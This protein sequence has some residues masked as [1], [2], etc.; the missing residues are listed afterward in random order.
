MNAIKTTA[1][2]VKT[3]SIRVIT[4][5]DRNS[6]QLET[7]KLKVQI[8]IA[9]GIDQ[10][11]LTTQTTLPVTISKVF[12]ND[13]ITRN[14]RLP[15]EFLLLLASNGAFELMNTN[16]KTIQQVDD[17]LEAWKN[18]FIYPSTYQQSLKKEPFN[19]ASFV[20][21][22]NTMLEQNQLTKEQ[23]AQWKAL[24][25]SAP[26]IK[27]LSAFLVKAYQSQKW[28]WLKILMDNEGYS[29]TPIDDSLESLL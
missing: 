25:A 21:L 15:V 6:Y 29:E 26:K 23:N 20:G 11:E 7:N 14:V 9:L 10:S 1:T 4:E 8:S 18:G 27:E 2:N 22:I 16:P 13:R 5:P 24:L 19:M 17:L 28:E 12:D 3:D